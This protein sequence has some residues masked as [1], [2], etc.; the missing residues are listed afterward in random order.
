MKVV[1][2]T[3]TNCNQLQMLM[4]NVTITTVMNLVIAI[5]AL[6]ESHHNNDL[7]D[8]NNR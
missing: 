2:K 4:I 3:V 6:I 7:A 1:M 5:L 8:E